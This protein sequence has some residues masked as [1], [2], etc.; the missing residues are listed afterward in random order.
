MTRAGPGRLA[1]GPYV[2][3][4]QCQRGPVCEVRPQWPLTPVPRGVRC[5]FSADISRIRKVEPRQKHKNCKVFRAIGYEFVIY[6]WTLDVGVRELCGGLALREPA[7][8]SSRGPRTCRPGGLQLWDTKVSRDFLF[9]C[10]EEKVLRRSR[11]F[12]EPEGR[13]AGTWPAMVRT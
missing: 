9:L 6:E 3:S 10:D 2:S 7:R 8:P 4:S 11:K 13:G 12:S 1:V 5:D